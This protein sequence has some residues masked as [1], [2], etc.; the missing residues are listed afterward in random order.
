MN[1]AHE[2]ERS[3][4]KVPSCGGPEQGTNAV[5]GSTRSETYETHYLALLSIFFQRGTRAEAA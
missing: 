4:R 3:F 2:F 5:R 1:P